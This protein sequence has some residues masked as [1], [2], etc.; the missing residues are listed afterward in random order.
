M[1]KVSNSVKEIRKHL[2]DDYKLYI[3]YYQ[4]SLCETI[5]YAV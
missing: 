4:M 2:H 3:R 5:E 1:D